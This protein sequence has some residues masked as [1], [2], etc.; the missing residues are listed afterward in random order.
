M[1]HSPGHSPVT[2]ADCKITAY[3]NG[4]LCVDVRF[5]TNSQLGELIQALS[6]LRDATALDHVHLQDDPN[7]SR[8]SVASTEIVFHLPGSCFDPSRKEMISHAERRIASMGQV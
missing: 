2:I 1:H 4:P 5:E 3:H 6:L 7:V 8:Q